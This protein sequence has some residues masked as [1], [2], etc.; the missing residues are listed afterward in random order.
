MENPFGSLP[1]IRNWK[2][3]DTRELL[4]RDLERLH[5]TDAYDSYTRRY[6]IDGVDWLIEAQMSRADGETLFILRCV[7]T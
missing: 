1:V 5:G 2:P 4:A 7:E 3:G 6:R